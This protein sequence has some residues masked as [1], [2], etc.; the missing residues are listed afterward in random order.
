MKITATILIVLG[1]IIGGWYYS[2]HKKPGNTGIC[3]NNGE[4]CPGTPGYE[5]RMKRELGEKFLTQEDAKIL[6]EKTWGKYI[7]QEGTSFNVTTWVGNG[8]II[9]S[10]TYGQADDSVSK[11]RKEAVATLSNGV[12]KLGEPTT[13]YACWPDRGHTDFSTEPCR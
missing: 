8:G 9:V 6:V 2:Q 11:V 5:A 7:P 1:L 4:F 10:A 13:T 12:W 3:G